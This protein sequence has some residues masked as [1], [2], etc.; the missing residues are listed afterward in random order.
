MKL[1]KILLSAVCLIVTSAHAQDPSPLVFDVAEHSFG[2]IRAIDGPVTHVFG[3]TNSGATPVAIDRI[4]VACGCTTPDFPRRTIAPG[5][6][7]SVRVTFD[8]TGYSGR[9]SKSISV[10][11][12][13]NKNRNFLTIS[14]FIESANTYDP[15]APENQSPNSEPESKKE[16]QKETQK[17]P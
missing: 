13:G 9:F 2:R 7:E 10:V 17:Q 6:R 15:Q 4:I 1:A 5:E 3:F 11:S 8:P 14:G 12:G 16:P